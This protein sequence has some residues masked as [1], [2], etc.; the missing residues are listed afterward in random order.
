[1]ARK[2]V[3]PYSQKLNILDIFVLSSVLTILGIRIFLELTGYPQ[4]GNGS[5][6]IAHMLWG[7]LALAASSLYMLLSEKPHRY[8]SA[9]VSGIGFGFFIDEIGKFVTSDNNYFFKPTAFLI[10]VLIVSIWIGVRFVIIRTYGGSFLSPAEWPTR[11]PLRAAIITYVVFQI[12][13]GLVAAAVLLINGADL[14]GITRSLE[15]FTF[16]VTLVLCLI[17]SIGIW[18]YYK[19]RLLLSANTLRIG[20]LISTVAVYPF[21]F[22]EQQFTAAIGCLLTVGMIIGLS[23]VSIKKLFASIWGKV[24]S[25][26]F[27][28]LENVSDPKTVDFYKDHNVKLDAY[29]KNSPYGHF[30]D[31]ISNQLHSDVRS[32]YVVHGKYTFWMERQKEWQ[33]AKLM[34]SAASNVRVLLDFENNNHSLD[35]WFPS[36]HGKYLIYGTSVNGNEETTLRLMR[37]EDGADV[38]ETIEFAGFTDQGAICWLDNE[39]EFIYP[40]MNG[41]DKKGPKDKWLLGTKLYK[42]V[43]GT[44]PSDDVCVYDPGSETVMLVPDLADDNNTLFVS[45]CEDE[46]THK[47]YKV[48]L[49]TL[50]ATLLNPGTSASCRTMTHKN[51]VYVVTNNSAEKYCLISADITS[52]PQSFGE[53]DELL[54][55]S[56]HV[57]RD[58]CIRSEGS[59]IAHYSDVTQSSVR[60]YDA[61]GNQTGRVE[62]GPGCTVGTLYGTNSNKEVIMTYS[63]YTVPPTIARIVLGGILKS[64][65]QRDAL[66]GDD[67]IAV[68]IYEAVSSDGTTIP[69]S[70]IALKGK[71]SRPTIAYG[72]G[73]FNIALE[74]YYLSTQRPWI[75]A[76]G[77]YVVMHLRGGS[78]KGEEWHRMGSMEHKQNTF[79]DCIAVGEDLIRRGFTTKDQL[80]VMGGSNGGLLVATVTVQ[81]PDLFRAGAA[82]VPLTDMLEFYKHQVAEFW[83]HEYGDPRIPEQKTWI[84]KWSPYHYPLKDE[85]YPAL[86][87]ETA[88]HD[89][90][91]HPFHA[92]KMVARLEKQV[93]EWKGPLLLRTKTDTGHQGSNMTKDD[94][95]KGIA[96]YYAFFANELGLPVP[97]K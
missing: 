97:A 59:I 91:V 55:E 79:D 29:I 38:F 9:F 78:E 16:T 51:K 41:Y 37:C 36:P 31:T 80:G 70:Y 5:L 68:D 82:L 22:Y 18:H 83:V 13:S 11:R 23:E 88:L 26:P 74:P 6:H 94:T 3:I 96:E 56:D 49:S 43:L 67:D 71:V 42:H 45:V 7:G 53:W 81:R 84:E 87:Y 15:D 46:L 54:P 21:T 72:Y 14:L 93:S 76:G 89:A 8:L 52:L 10:Y 95:V 86:Y 85:P 64:V 27:K 39:K 73:G 44:D 90:R 75:L 35:Y 12:I 28:Y 40:R 20:G 60:I 30:Y 17:Y 77:A 48:D 61:Y 34:I 47:V 66:V 24:V 92:F 50:S 69:Y 19:G 33:K 63:G 4:I 58:V 32:G 2:V 62:L 1:M 65:W 25:D 57:L